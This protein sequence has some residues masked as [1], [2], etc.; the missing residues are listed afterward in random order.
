MKA[1][2]YQIC[3]NDGV[4]RPKTETYCKVCGSGNKTLPLAQFLFSFSPSKHSRLLNL[5]LENENK[6]LTIKNARVCNNC[7]N[8]IPIKN[9]GNVCCICQS[10]DIQ[11]LFVIR[12]D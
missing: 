7:E 5:K 3:L 10:N 1:T 2:D 9:S 8:V 12:E 4:I 11:K 6:L